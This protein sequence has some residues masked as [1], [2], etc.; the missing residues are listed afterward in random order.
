MNRLELVKEKF[1]EVDLNRVLS[2]DH[3]KSKKYSLWIAKQLSK[4][5]REEDIGPTVKLFDESRRR[6]SLEDRDI[7]QHDDLK[8][9]EDKLKDLGSSKRKLKGLKKAKS[10]DMGIHLS[11]AGEEYRIIRIDDKSASVEYGKNTRWCVTMANAQYFE[12]YSGR[13]TLFYFLLRVNPKGDEWDK[14]AMTVERQSGNRVACWDSTDRQ[15][16]NDKFTQMWEKVIEPDARDR[17][18]FYYAIAEGL[19]TDEEFL[20]WWEEYKKELEKSK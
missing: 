19:L 9:I 8:T 3:S 2:L 17:N 6:L 11:D 20:E 4:G 7:Y 13:N 12:D 18:T 15:H 5:H 14:V 1:P 16:K 10:E